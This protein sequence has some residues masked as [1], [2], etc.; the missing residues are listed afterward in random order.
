[1]TDT[2]VDRGPEH[3]RNT[4]QK[5]NMEN[6]KE[7][8]TLFFSVPPTHPANNPPSCNIPDDQNKP[9]SSNQPSVQRQRGWDYE[10]E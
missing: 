9:P 6:I 2:G 1:M 10:L 8:K 3:A 5:N 4:Q 7:D